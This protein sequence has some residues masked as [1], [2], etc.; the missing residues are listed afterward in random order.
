MPL[1]EHTT[2]AL[3][4]SPCMPSPE[5]LTRPH[6]CPEQP[7]DTGPARFGAPH[8][9]LSSNLRFGDGHAGRVSGQLRCMR[10]RRAPCHPHSMFTARSC[11]HLRAGFPFLRLSEGLLQGGAGCPGCCWLQGAPSYWSNL[12]NS[13]CSC[14]CVE[15]L[16]Y[17]QDNDSLNNKE[18]A[19]P[20]TGE[21]VGP[22]GRRYRHK[23]VKFPNLTA[24]APWLIKQLQTDI[25]IVIY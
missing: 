5:T 10:V 4:P 25:L 24:G 1:V 13:C 20:K 8:G 11:S 21:F 7:Y 15:S 22:V 16:P 12:C 9:Q 14:S 19:S 23:P 18:K 6:R 2:T 3:L 17:N